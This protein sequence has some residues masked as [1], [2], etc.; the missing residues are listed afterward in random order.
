MQFRNYLLNKEKFG[1][2]NTDTQ[3]PVPTNAS[4][5]AVVSLHCTNGT[6]PKDYAFCMYTMYILHTVSNT[7]LQCHK[8]VYTK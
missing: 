3:T 5:L 2:I 4:A 6:M 7:K 1:P 8:N